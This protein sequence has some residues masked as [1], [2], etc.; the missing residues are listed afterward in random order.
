MFGP[1]GM[2]FSWAFDKVV[3]KIK[4]EEPKGPIHTLIDKA[5]SKD[6]GDTVEDKIKTH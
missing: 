4:G 6:E 3:S 1:L 5:I 2:L